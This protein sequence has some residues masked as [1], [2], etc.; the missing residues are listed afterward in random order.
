MTLNSADSGES[1]ILGA[2][3]ADDM[4]AE[5]MKRASRLDP[6]MFRNK[7]ARTLAWIILTRLDE[8]R[9][10][11]LPDIIRAAKERDTLRQLGGTAALCEIQFCAPVS[12][13]LLE[14]EIN[15]LETAA[16][17][18]QLA[19]LCGSYG[20][21]ARLE[22]ADLP[23][24]VGGIGRDTVALLDSKQ[25]DIV[26]VGEVV[27][28]VVAG[29]QDPKQAG[30]STGFGGIN[31]YIGGLKGGRV[32]ILGARPSVGKT[33]LALGIA[34]NVARQGRPVAV[35]SLE[36]SAT[37]ITKRLVAAEGGINLQA[38]DSG[39]L[40]DAEAALTGRAA[41]AIGRWPLHVFAGR[42]KGL[43]AIAAHSQQLQARNGLGLV[44]ID[45]LQ[46]LFGKRAEN[47]QQEVAAISAGV[48]DLAQHLG[49]PILAL[50]QL[51]RG[52]EDRRNSRP[53]MSDLRESGALEQDADV[54]LLMWRPHKDTDQP[55]DIAE[56]CVAKN[57][58]GA[59]GLGS[60]DWVPYCA[61]FDAPRKNA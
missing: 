51:K 43:H 21:R 14:H 55:D 61:R 59:T 35:F 17:K 56:F 6:Q 27:G 3:L 44:V 4:A 58:H 11:K 5:L 12:P 2:A 38:L 45:Y 28:D 19:E 13:E 49:V 33:A 37:E 54:V 7:A 50:S 41:A 30:V 16:N 10:I 15:Q 31:H 8:G 36:M 42:N 52:A 9:P 32:Y 26:P 1:I 20:A 39:E 53:Q 23:D 47:R 46:L 40:C 25:A 48:K 18:T 57:R 22:S 34:A 24:L 29:M 60:L